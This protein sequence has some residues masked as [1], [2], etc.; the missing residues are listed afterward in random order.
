MTV[1]NG[2]SPAVGMH[3]AHWAAPLVAGLAIVTSTSDAWAISISENVRPDF[4]ATNGSV[5]SAVQSGNI[6]YIA[7]WFTAVGPPSG[8][9]VPV[10][11]ANG[12]V[13]AVFPRVG[14][15]V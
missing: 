6:L 10:D 12:S 14:G 13:P 9:G 11:A 8:G 5:S 2:F 4:C 3:W 7:G 15:I 1:R